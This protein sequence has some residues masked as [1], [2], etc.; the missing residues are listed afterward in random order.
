VHFEIIGEN[1]RELFDFYRSVFDWRI[2]EIMDEYSL[3]SSGSGLDAK[4]AR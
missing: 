3:V 1:M 4:W 2:D